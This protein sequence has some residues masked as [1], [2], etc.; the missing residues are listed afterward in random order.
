MVEG[1][2]FWDL[3]IGFVLIVLKEKYFHCSKSTLCVCECLISLT[4]FSELICLNFDIYQF[5]TL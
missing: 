4:A 1:T 2:C 5:Q 3:A